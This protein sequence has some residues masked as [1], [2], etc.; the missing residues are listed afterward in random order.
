MLSRRDLSR[1]GRMAVAIMAVVIWISC[2][3]AG[4]FA[5]DE[6]PAASSLDEQLLDD[7]DNE[8]LK[9]AGKDAAKNDDE[10]P[11]DDGPDSDDEATGDAEQN[12]FSRVAR[13]MRVAEGLIPKPKSGDK[14][15]E[16]QERI[17]A[18][19]AKI[20]E[21]VRKQSQASS[22]GS[23]PR[24]GSAGNNRGQNPKQ[25][26]TDK[27]NDQRSD[28]PSRNSS[29]RVGK[30]DVRRPDMAAMKGLMKDAWGNLPQREREQMMQAPPDE[31][32]PKYELL[33][34]NF[35]KRLADEQ[36][37]RP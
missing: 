8:L 2:R 10:Q 34:E 37:N 13:Q 29:N 4:T 25:S 1:T 26:S 28:K 19:L 9:G 21:Q 35:Y 7:L 5:A 23:S 15:V 3:A 24:R 20:I 31:F 16:L 14:T 27:P 6:K 22:S 36:K 17:V 33:I 30:N 18:D 32:L 11:S 12:P